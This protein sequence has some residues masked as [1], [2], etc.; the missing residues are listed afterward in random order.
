MY[1]CWGEIHTRIHIHVLQLK[2]FNIYVSTLLIIKK[3][4]ID[5]VKLVNITER[6][7]EGEREREREILI[8]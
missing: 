2:I 4:K 7:R 3:S 8:D 1:V 6:E 5:S